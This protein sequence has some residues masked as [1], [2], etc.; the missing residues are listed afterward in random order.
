MISCVRIRAYAPGDR[1][2]SRFYVRSGCVCACARVCTRDRYRVHLRDDSD[3][4]A[5]SPPAITR[6]FVSISGSDAQR[7]T[8]HFP[9]RFPP[10]PVRLIYLY[11]R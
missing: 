3:G 8:Y 5:R 10:P 2:I 11:I 7:F 9:I 1:R 6:A 4:A